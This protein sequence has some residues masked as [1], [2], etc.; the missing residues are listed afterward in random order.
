MGRTGEALV[1]QRALVVERPHDKRVHQE[2]EILEA[3]DDDPADAYG[4]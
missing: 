2:L 1:M 4:A 3:V